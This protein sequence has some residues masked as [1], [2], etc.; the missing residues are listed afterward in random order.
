MVRCS[1]YLQRSTVRLEM[2]VP[3]VRITYFLVSTR[4]HLFRYSRTEVNTI[5][6]CA[7]YL[8]LATAYDIP[9]MKQDAIKALTIS[10]PSRLAYYDELTEMPQDSI[11]RP[12]LSRTTDDVIAAIFL[13]RQYGISHILPC[14][15]LLCCALTHDNFLAGVDNALK[16]LRGDDEDSNIP[17][18]EATQLWLLRTYMSLRTVAETRPFLVEF[19]CTGNCKMPQYCRQYLSGQEIPVLLR[20]HSGNLLKPRS[21]PAEPPYYAS[22]KTCK[23]DILKGQYHDGRVKVW[24]ELP[25]RFGLGTWEEIRDT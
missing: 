10:F 18:A 24:N 9:R 12:S 23:W 2:D 21:F 6:L 19:Q 1:R 14:A 17:S 25:V 8:K 4:S 3:R 13:G 11:Y 16:N 7:L 20:P 22:R 5:A 15:L